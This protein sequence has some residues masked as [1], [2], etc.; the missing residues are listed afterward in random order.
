[1]ASWPAPLPVARSSCGE[2]AAIERSGCGAL[3]PC[4]GVVLRPDAPFGAHRIERNGAAKRRRSFPVS[5]R[6]FPVR[7]LPSF[8]SSLIW[9]RVSRE[10]N[11]SVNSFF[12]FLLNLSLLPKTNLEPRKALIPMLDP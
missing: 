11:V 6:A 10:G 5:L 7:S 8:P 1:M 12:D 3:C 4:W 2:R 9:V